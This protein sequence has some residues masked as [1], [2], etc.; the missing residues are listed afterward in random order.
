MN[1]KILIQIKKNDISKKKNFIN[2]I[3]NNI[4]LIKKEKKEEILKIAISL[5]NYIIYN[6]YKYYFIYI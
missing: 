2:L 3:Q 1:L 4:E 6:T 5:Y